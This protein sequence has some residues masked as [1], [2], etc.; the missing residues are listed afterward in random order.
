MVKT[1]PSAGDEHV[2]SGPSDKEIAV[3]AYDQYGGR[4]AFIE[5]TDKDNPI[6]GW[7]LRSSLSKCQN[8]KPWKK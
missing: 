7:V 1:M 8:I 5:N 3:D 2:L 4:W 6:T